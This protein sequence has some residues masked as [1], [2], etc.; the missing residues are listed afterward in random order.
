MCYV[1]HPQHLTAFGLKVSTYLVISDNR[2]I[3]A[4]HVHSVVTVPVSVNDL[5]D[6]SDGVTPS[7]EGRSLTLRFNSILMP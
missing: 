5:N 6:P 4:C 2:H 1:A 3:C 7:T